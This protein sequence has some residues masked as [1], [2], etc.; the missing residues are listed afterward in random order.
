MS[1]IRLFINQNISL[2]WSSGHCTVLRVYRHPLPSEPVGRHLAAAFSEQLFE[3]IRSQVYS[4]S[5]F[6]ERT[7]ES[8]KRPFGKTTVPLLVVTTVFTPPMPVTSPET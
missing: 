2:R 3:V 4:A 1:L 6:G 5:D 8:S 7:R